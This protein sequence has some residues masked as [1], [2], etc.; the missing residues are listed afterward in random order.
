VYIHKYYLVESEAKGWYPLVSKSNN[1]I[2]VSLVLVLVFSVASAAFFAPKI[3]NNQ[4]N[5][6]EAIVT[7]RT[8]MW[9]SINSG[10][11]GSGELP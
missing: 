2:Y 5:Y 7:A 11:I 3:N 8:E 10:Q 4:D 9:Q 1:L 6:K